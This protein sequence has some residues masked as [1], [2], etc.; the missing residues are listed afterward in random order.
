[1]DNL[2]AESLPEKLYIKNLSPKT[3]NPIGKLS[4]GFGVLICL[5][6]HSTLLS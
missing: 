3:K 5:S 1:M 6:Q 2:F 4:T